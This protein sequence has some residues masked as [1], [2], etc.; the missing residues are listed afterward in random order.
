MQDGGFKHIFLV[1]DSFLTHYKPK[2]YKNIS[3]PSS[4]RKK[5]TKLCENLSFV[6]MMCREKKVQIILH[7][8]KLKASILLRINS[9]LVLKYATRLNQ[10]VLQIYLR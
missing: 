7:I 6:F 8:S 4:R 3:T 2:R 10:N 5:E 1:L 9:Y